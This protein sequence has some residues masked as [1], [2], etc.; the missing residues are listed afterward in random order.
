MEI[1]DLVAQRIQIVR[2]VE[3]GVIEHEARCGRTVVG[4]PN[5]RLEETSRLD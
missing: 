5:F 1:N 4:D 3:V 2:V